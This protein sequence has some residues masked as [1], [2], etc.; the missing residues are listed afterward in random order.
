MND[1][2]KYILLYLYCICRAKLLTAEAFYAFIIY[3]YGKPFFLIKNNGM[4][5]TGAHALS[6]TQTL[7]GIYGRLWL[8]QSHKPS[9][10]HP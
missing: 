7:L 8:E 4:L 2:Y 10:S 3:Y 5:R 6:A 9:V 1:P